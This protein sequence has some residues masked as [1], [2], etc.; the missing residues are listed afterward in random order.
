MAITLPASPSI[1]DEYL[2]GGKT[3][4]WTGSFWKQSGKYAIIDA[5]FSE[6]EITAEALTADG[7]NA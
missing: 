3:F 6:T 1:D 2:V 5:G 7:G 4:V